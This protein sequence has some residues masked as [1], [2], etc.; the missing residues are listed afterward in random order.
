MIQ[1]GVSDGDRP[2]YF[3]L[4]PAIVTDL[5]DPDRLGRVEVK[6][7]WLGSEGE[8]T[9]RAWATLLSP[10]ADDGQ[11]LFALPEKDSQVVVGFEAGDPRRP[12]IVGSCWNGVEA[13][14]VTAEAPNNKRVFKTRSQSELEFDDT[15]GSPKITL[16][17]AAGH[18]LV[19]DEGGGE[20]TLSHANGCTI[21]INQGG[22]IEI[23]AN[24]TVELNAAS[25]NVHAPMANFDGMVSC[26]T[27]IA[28]SAVVSPSYSPGAG[29]IW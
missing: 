6:F 4:Y 8:R 20:V 1:K 28:S 27:L 23:Q 18:S 16:T 22:Q 17:T 24:S 26:T 5:V 14:P 11:G 3:G 12:Y 2:G 10:Y 25:L 29:N 13:T 9:V 19:I 21:R 15:Q 7:P